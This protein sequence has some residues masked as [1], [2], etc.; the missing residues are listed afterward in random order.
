MADTILIIGQEFDPHVDCVVAAFRSAGVHCVRWPTSFFPSRS[1]LQYAFSHGSSGG[2]IEIEGRVIEL[3]AI[4]SVWYRHTEPFAVPQRV[5]AEEKRFA[6]KENSSAFWGLLRLGD[7]FWV[8]HPDRIPAASSKPLQLRVARELG[9]EIPKTLITNDPAAVQ[10]FFEECRGTMIYKAFNSGFD[11][12]RGKGCFCSPVTVEHLRKLH[13]IRKSA[14][15]FQEL[16]PKRFDLRITV[17]GS[18]VFAA[19]IHSQDHQSSRY[20]WR[21]VQD[22][23]QLRHSRH[24]LPASLQ[25]ACLELVSR[26]GLAYG[27]IDMILTPD[28]RYVFLENNPMGQFGWIEAQTGL[29]LTSALAEMLVAGHV[30]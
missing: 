10:A 29:P 22:I 11:L 4:R 18:R 1:C 8:N 5:S 30:I 24:E 23:E 20:D 21:A 13:L 12:S 27:A 14:G 9:L 28:D 15:M 6:D 17:I 19:E 7:W 3:D 26:F 2:R 25:R 16:V